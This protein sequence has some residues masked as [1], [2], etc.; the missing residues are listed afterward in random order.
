MLQYNHIRLR[1]IRNT[2]GINR[3]LINHIGKTE[4]TAEWISEEMLSM[5]EAGCYKKL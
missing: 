5:D 2:W 3:N 1:N 4:V